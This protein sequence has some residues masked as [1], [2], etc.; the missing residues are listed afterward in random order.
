MSNR[1]MKILQLVACALL[2][3]G[4][5]N[6][7]KEYYFFMKVFVG[8]LSVYLV[9]VASETK[10]IISSILLLCCAIVFSPITL[11][12]VQKSG[13][14]WLNSIGAAVFALTFFTIWHPAEQAQATEK[15]ES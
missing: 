8:A 7:P 6:L 10:K 12:T 4:I 9:F 2:L 5:A 14:V 15:S 3:T 13:W 11:I 1:A